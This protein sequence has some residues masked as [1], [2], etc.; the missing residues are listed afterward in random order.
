[1]NPS[2]APRQIPNRARFLASR[3]IDRRHGAIGLVVGAGLLSVVSMLYA[4]IVVPSRDYRLDPAHR[5]VQWVLPGGASWGGGLRAGETVVRL[6]QGEMD[7]EWELI[8]TGPA[9]VVVGSDSTGQLRALRGTLPAA[10]AAIGLWLGA[11]F[12]LVGRSRLSAVLAL[13][14][15]GLGSVPLAASN[16]LVM[17]SAGQTLGPLLGAAW[18]ASDKRVPR[19]RWVLGITG[20]VLIAWLVA[21]A[22]IPDLYTLTEPLRV[23]VFGTL[24]GMALFYAIRWN[25]WLTSSV[26]IDPSLSVDV[27]A[28]ILVLALAVVAAALGV[29]IWIVVPI[30]LGLLAI[31]SR[32][33][34]RL[35]T[36]IEQLVFGGIRDHA[37]VLAS[38]EER[39]RLASE[40][41]D[42]PL[43]ELAAAIGELDEQPATESAASLLRDVA[44]QLRSVTTALRP[45]VLD[46]L[47][48]GPAVAWL[49]EQSSHRIGSE[50]RIACNIED[51]TRV[52][53]TERPPPDV[54]LAVFRI[55]Q[56]ALNNAVRHAGGTQ[57]QVDGR[58]SRVL[59]EL[60]VR[61][62]GRGIDDGVLRDARRAGR[63]GIPSMRQRA[64]SIEADLT[65]GRLPSGG[66]SITLHW[67]RG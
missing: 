8:A 63:L 23:A 58:L 52:G 29:A 57:I 56:E 43:Q 14:S 12:L 61:D 31:Y 30:S 4:V 33:R 34:R 42:G 51:A 67:A 11:V 17:A 1:M 19:R 41:H 62:D 28:L 16:Q 5:E 49:V 9:G 46:D 53:R 18:I 26:R 44:A 3:I 24:I 50:T 60:T 7:A 45:P 13:V 65:I 32:I 35:G 6:A 66:T 25:T 64:D 15:L 10:L 40:I 54:E 39:A 22:W 2:L 55:V 47:G 38:E 27:G 36:A 59:V 48:L 20:A 37:A 21:R